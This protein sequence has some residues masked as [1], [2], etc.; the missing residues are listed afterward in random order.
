MGRDLLGYT[1]QIISKEEGGEGAW[2]ADG[3]NA[4]L[5]LFR[6]KYL[7]VKSFSFK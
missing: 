5:T 3:E 2:Q 4:H 1:S 7:P 6:Q